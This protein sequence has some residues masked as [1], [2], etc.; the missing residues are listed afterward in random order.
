LAIVSGGNRGIGLAV[1]R[2]LA[3]QG[4]TVLLG[5][6]DRERGQAAAAQLQQAG[7][8]VYAAELDVSNGQS[9][10]DFVADLRQ[11]YSGLAVLV[12]NAALYLDQGVGVEALPEEDYLATLNVNVLG[13]FRLTKALLPL[14]RANDYGR[15]VNVSSGLGQLNGMGG[16]SLAYRSSKAALNAFTQVLAQELDSHRFKVNSVCPG[17]VHTQMGGASAPRSPAQAAAG[18]VWA[19]T[20]GAD[21]PTG[22]FFRDGR[23]I[24]W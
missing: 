16:H 2:Q 17:W 6:R 7:L 5:S 21:G 1:C 11:Q 8:A 24:E 9:I 13:A 14:L 20:L 3:E 12:N 4:H 19:A 10:D 23:R 15:I 18:I 22:G